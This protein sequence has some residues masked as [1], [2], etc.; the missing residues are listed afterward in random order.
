[1]EF[2]RTANE[3]QSK[4]KA[5]GEVL[6]YERKLPISERYIASENVPSPLVSNKGIDVAHLHF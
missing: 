5:L 3:I 2:K 4:T 1:M 6:F